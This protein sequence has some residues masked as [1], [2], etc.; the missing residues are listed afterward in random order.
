MAQPLPSGSLKNTKRPQGNSCTSLASTP[1][2]TS[3]A[4][5]ASASAT[6]TWRLWSEPGG[7][8]TIPFPMAIEHAEPGGVSCTKRI[9]SLTV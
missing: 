7:V 3:R 9:S 2:S 1:R 6:T 8:S 4:L 5:A